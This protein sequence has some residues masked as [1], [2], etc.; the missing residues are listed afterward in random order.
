MERLRFREKGASFTP[1]LGV[2][3]TVHHYF[4][5]DVGDWRFFHHAESHVSAEGYHV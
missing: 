3:E 5:N 4:W 1:A 2:V